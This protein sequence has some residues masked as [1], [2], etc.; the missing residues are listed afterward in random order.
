TW[1]DVEPSIMGTLLTRALD[2]VERHRL[3][4]EYTPREFVE[5]VVRPTV[6]E[7]IRERWTAVQ[8]EVLQLRNSSSKSARAR[9][10][11]EK[12]ALAR[13]REFHGWLRALR[14]LDPACGSGNFLYV[15]LAIVKQVELEVLRTI[16]EI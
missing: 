15:T 11:N 6:E 10:D 9:R 12:T 14:F 13:L 3:G 2:P 4:A 7:P 16:E 1:A 5:R 8:A